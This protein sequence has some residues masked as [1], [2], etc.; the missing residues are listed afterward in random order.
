MS[1]DDLLLVEVK[2]RLCRV[3]QTKR[4]DVLTIKLDLD[5]YVDV[6][7]QLGLLTSIAD[8][9]LPDEVQHMFR[10]DLLTITSFPITR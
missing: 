8:S 9:R 7:N 4:A 10:R 2:T 1:A 6:Y 3:L 5:I